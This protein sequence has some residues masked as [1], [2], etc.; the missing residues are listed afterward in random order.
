MGK[1][2]WGGHS[3]PSHIPWGLGCRRQAGCHLWAEP[4]LLWALKTP[5]GSTGG[6]HRRAAT[7]RHAVQ[8][9]GLSHTS[10][11]DLPVPVPNK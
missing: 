3:R 10:S 7:C 6:L 4:F 2:L 1:D 11:L 8:A 9:Q 5:H